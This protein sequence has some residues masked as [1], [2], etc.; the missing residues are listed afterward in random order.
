MEKPASSTAV[1]NASISASVPSLNRIAK[2]EFLISDFTD[3]T[4]ETF[5]RALCTALLHIAQVKPVAWSR[6]ELN[7][8]REEKES[9]TKKTATK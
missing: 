2:D 4:K 6:A 9:T 3:S 1:L 7:W 8:A 5:C